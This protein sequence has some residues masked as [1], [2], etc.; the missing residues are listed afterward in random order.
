MNLSINDQRARDLARLLR[1][2]DVRAETIIPGDVLVLHYGI[3]R[4]HRTYRDDRICRWWDD[5]EN[6]GAYER[7]ETVRILARDILRAP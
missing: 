1:T 2:E 7:G 3:I 6:G 5:E 4:V